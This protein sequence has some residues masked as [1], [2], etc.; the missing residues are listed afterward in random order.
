[1]E[2]KYILARRE[3]VHVRIATFLKSAGATSEAL[4]NKGL[5]ILT[6]QLL[7]SVYKVVVKSFWETDSLEIE[8]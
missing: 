6:S 8:C 2:L 4:A 1:M 3:E 5:I 7:E